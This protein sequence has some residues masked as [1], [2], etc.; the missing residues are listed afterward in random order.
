MKFDVDHSFIDPRADSRY[1]VGGSPIPIM[2]LLA[3]YALFCKVGPAIMESRKPFELKSLMT[4]Y[5]F[6][7]VAL[8]SYLG[9]KVEIYIETE[10]Y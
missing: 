7:Q 2:S 5:N 1:F 8:N 9:C 4:A 10:L 3:C 6:V